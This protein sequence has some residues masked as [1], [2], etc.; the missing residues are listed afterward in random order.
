MTHFLLG[1]QRVCKEEVHNCSPYPY[2]PYLY[3]GPRTLY[4]R[5][6]PIYPHNA[7]LSLRYKGCQSAQASTVDRYLPQALPVT[8]DAPTGKKQNISGQH[9]AMPD[10][11][12][13]WS[14]PQVSKEYKGAIYVIYGN[15]TE[16]G[17]K[18]L[19]ERV[20]NTDPYGRAGVSFSI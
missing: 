12:R 1:M 2:L 5:L 14:H 16:E 6:R 18:K 17:H 15:M 3:Y 10:I 13:V 11:Y 7:T 8:I 4:P 9:L 20:G 19:L